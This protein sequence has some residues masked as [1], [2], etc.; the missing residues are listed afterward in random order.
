MNDGGE[1]N[2]G[3]IFVGLRI[4]PDIAGQL[5]ALAAE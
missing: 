3:R 1:T 5:A 4:S 2:P